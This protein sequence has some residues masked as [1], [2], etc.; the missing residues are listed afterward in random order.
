M[1]IQ[2]KRHKEKKKGDRRIWNG[3][4]G[5]RKK[6]TVKGLLWGARKGWVESEQDSLN[7]RKTR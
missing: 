3:R 6:W 5:G 2:K 4:V 7:E 1:K